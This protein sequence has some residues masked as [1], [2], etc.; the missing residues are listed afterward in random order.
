V[1]HG[2][3]LVLAARKL[4]L[5]EVPAIRVTELSEARLRVLRL[6]LNRLGEESS[7]AKDALSL[8]FQEILELDDE[9]ELNLSGFEIGEIDLILGNAG[10]EDEPPVRLPDAVKEPVSKPGD[11]WELGPHRILCGDA[12]KRESYERLLGVEKAQIIFTDPPYNVAIDG[13]VSGLGAVKHGDFA[14]ASGELTSS[15]FEQFLKTSLSLSA[16]H[17]EDG[18]IHF[19][20]M[21]W[22]HLS[23]LLVAGK[24]VYSELKNLCV[25][26]KTNG[27]MGSLYRSKHE[28]VL[29]Y[30][31][32]TAPHINNVALGRH[33]RNRSN[34]WDYAGANVLGEARQSML[35]VHPTV[36]PVQLV[37]E[38]ILD[39]SK[40]QG[41]VLDPFGGAGSTL[42]AAERVGRRAALIELEPRY[43]DVTL[44]RW[45]QLPDE[46]P[47]LVPVA[48]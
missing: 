5:P 43:V 22:R 17:S 6:A 30:K 31:A 21:D 9:L 35:E 19:V 29:V 44:D 39:C 40:P 47:E 1:V 10:K 46:E 23:E 45:R 38:A 3:G 14:M 33:G 36:K 42:I 8:E 7:W 15:E 32:G 12:L 4:E 20:C 2:W 28:L 25:W 11:L 18:A 48:P 26:N 41:L 27:G 34:V 16:E 37:A 13:H 24:A